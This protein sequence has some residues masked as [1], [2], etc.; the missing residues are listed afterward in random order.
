MSMLIRINDP[1]RAT[2]SDQDQQ[3]GG[4]PEHLLSLTEDLGQKFKKFLNPYIEDSLMI[5]L[6]L[7]NDPPRAP[8][9]GPTGKGAS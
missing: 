7:I 4:P 5:V 6:I 2:G 3:V 9:S 8:G 1:P